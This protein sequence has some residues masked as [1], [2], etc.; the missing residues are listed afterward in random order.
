MNKQNDISKS[1]NYP[2][3]GINGKKYI[4]FKQTKFDS[5]GSI[6]FADNKKLIGKVFKINSINNLCNNN[7]TKSVQLSITYPEISQEVS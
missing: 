5:Y 7:M 4:V 1:D 6:R 2:Q 3:F